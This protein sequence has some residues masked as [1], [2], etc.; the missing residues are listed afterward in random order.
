MSDPLY[1]RALRILKYEEAEKEAWSVYTWSLHER[2]RNHCLSIIKHTQKNLM[3]DIAD[4][5]GSLVGSVFG[6]EQGLSDVIADLLVSWL[7]AKKSTSTT[8]KFLFGRYDVKKRHLILTETDL[9]IASHGMDLPLVGC[10]AVTSLE[11]EDA[12]VFF[13]MLGYLIAYF[14]RDQFPTARIKIYL[15]HTDSELTFS[16]RDLHKTLKKSSDWPKYLAINVS[17]DSTSYEYPA[18][19]RLGIELGPI[20]D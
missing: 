3:R 9:R 6:E 15:K 8:K 12:F 13:Q 17:D 2:Y 19:D 11:S 14:D 7:R 10:R 20:D 18:M 16:V 1:A 5:D 4:F